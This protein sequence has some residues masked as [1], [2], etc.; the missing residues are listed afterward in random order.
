MGRDELALQMGGK[1][2]QLDAGIIQRAL[3]LVAVGLR[4][5][6]LGEVEQAGVPGRDLHA[7]EAVPGCPLGNGAEVIERI[8]IARELG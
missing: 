7:L 5:S 1:L 2:R 4:L 6:G 3:D 8:G